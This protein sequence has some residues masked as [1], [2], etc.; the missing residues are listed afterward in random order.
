MTETCP[1]CKSKLQFLSSIELGHTFNLGTKYSQAMGANFNDKDSKSKPAIMGCYGIGLGR[2]L[3]AVAE[4]NHDENGIIWPKVVAP[5]A[6]HLIQLG[7]DKKVKKAAEK[8]YQDLQKQC[9]EVLYD[10]RDKK[11][12]GEKFV[13]A[14]LIGIPIR[15]VVSER[16]LELDSVEIKKRNEQ[17]TKFIK[18]H[19]LLHLVEQLVAPPGGATE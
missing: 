13:E 14:D 7:D 15:M 17:K 8:V 12:A 10:D 5:F 6:V 3:G 19:G 1:E 4:L 18:I 11:S 16:T 2:L 9:I